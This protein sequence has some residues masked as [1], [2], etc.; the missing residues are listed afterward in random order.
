MSY[1]ALKNFCINNNI[2]IIYKKK[3]S[4]TMDIAK[5]IIPKKYKDLL[6]ITDFQT[7]GRG[8]LGNKW[9][10]N[11]G[12]IFITLKFFLEKKVYKYPEIAIL[13]LIEIKKTLNNLNIQNVF[14][15]WP[16]DIYIN[17]D[18]VGGILT[19]IYNYKSKN[20]CL[21]GIG[22]NLVKSPKIN[23]YKTTYL[24]QYNNSIK[25]FL[26]IESLVKNI[27]L[28]FNIWK[29]HKNINLIKDYKKNL[30]YFGKKIII[31]INNNKSIIGKFTDL[32]KEG[33]VIINRQNKREVVFSGSMDLF[34]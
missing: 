17:D 19:E 3:I 32:T 22:I 27:V 4:S 34:K 20:Y 9:I 7:N 16:N 24:H 28:N 21:L 2:D 23:N 14:F 5:K 11:K 12:N 33:Y 25:K 1:P 31:N 15:K 29:K 6:V 30:M 10:S 18:K 8:R 13:S 26:L